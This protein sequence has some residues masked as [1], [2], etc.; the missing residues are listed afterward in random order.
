MME[1]YKLSVNYNLLL[2]YLKRNTLL[3]GEELK[4]FLKVFMKQ[5]F[6]FDNLLALINFY[7]SDIIFIYKILK[8]VKE[9]KT[10]NKI[11]F[12]QYLLKCS[13][14]FLEQLKIKYQ[15]KK[16]NYNKLF[17][18]E[19][20]NFEQILELKEKL[21][22]YRY[23]EQISGHLYLFFTPIQIEKAM[24]F[25]LF[26]D[27]NLE[28]FKGNTTKIELIGLEN[29]EERSFSDIQNLNSR[30]KRQEMVQQHFRDREKFL[31]E[32]QKKSKFWEMNLSEKT[33]AVITKIYQTF[34]LFMRVPGNSK[35]D[36][37]EKFLI[38]ISLLFFFFLDLVKKL[39]FFFNF[40]L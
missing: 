3:E 17:H 21:K 14:G 4:T 11:F 29:L 26:D 13:F 2:Y 24:R 8:I 16:F 6:Y 35:L 25:K 23:N 33:L 7:D 12:S 37:N 32:L 31:K 27:E 1:P 28:N 19:G 36:W 39:F 10:L 22:K 40:L 9:I 38:R 15:L 5:I 18:I 20:K 34:T 30:L